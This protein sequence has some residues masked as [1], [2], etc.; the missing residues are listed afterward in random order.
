MRKL[1]FT[2]LACL[3]LLA[4]VCSS[5]QA[6]TT[7][8]NLVVF[9]DSLS[10]TGNIG[11]YSNG[12]IWVE[13]LST[14]L[15]AALYN[16]ASAG[17]TTGNDNPAAGLDYTGLLWQVDDTANLHYIP[18]LITGTSLVALW[19]GANDFLQGR[20]YQAAV[21]NIEIALESLYDDGFHYFMVP[22]LPDIGATP[23]FKYYKLSTESEAA[24]AWTNAFN[25]ALANML[26]D[27]VADEENDGVVL[28]SLDIYT[29]FGGYE[30]GSADW[31]A[32]FWTDYFHPSSTGHALIASI[33]GSAVPVPHTAFLLVTGLLGLTL[34]GRK[35]RN[36]IQG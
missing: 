9:G 17:A 21:D 34:A 23:L 6:A 4:G 14:N 33:A 29:A 22:N 12:D 30:I 16:Y 19:A 32:L 28:Y 13:T 10:D 35:W 2:L 1:Y 18:S 27:F 25:T 11:R 31:A 7:F 24:T 20:D 26:A 5:V 36:R 15:E 8:N 3:F